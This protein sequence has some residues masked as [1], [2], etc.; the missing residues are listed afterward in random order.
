[1]WTRSS[2]RGLIKE[3]WN[4]EIPLSTLGCYLARWGFSVQRPVKRAYHQ[5]EKKIK[6]W[7]ETELPGIPERAKTEKTEIYVGNE[8]GLRNTASCLR[9]YAPIGK[10]P[11]VKTEANGSK[12]ICVPLFPPVGNLGLYFIKTT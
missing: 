9:G 5:D 3:K 6:N 8:T 1:M 12:S 10:T 4:I 2:I 7:L 11:V